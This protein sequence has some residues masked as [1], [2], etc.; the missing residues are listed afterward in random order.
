MSDSNWLICPNWIEVRCFTK[1]IKNNKTL[2]DTIFIDTGIVMGVH[3]D[4]P[5]L[6][7]RRNEVKIEEARKIWQNLI[8]EGWQITKPKW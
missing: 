3:G 6:M 5:P 8:S 1:K 7:K 4:K 2:V